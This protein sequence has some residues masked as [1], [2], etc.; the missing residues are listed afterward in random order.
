MKNDFAATSCTGWKVLA[1]GSL[2]NHGASALD[3]AAG[4]GHLSCVVRNASID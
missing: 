1:P 3:W 2:D 4:G